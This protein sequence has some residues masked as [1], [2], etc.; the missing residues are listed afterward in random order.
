MSR[1]DKK[2][3]KESLEPVELAAI[4]PKIMTKP[5][6]EILDELESAIKQNKMK[7]QIGDWIRKLKE[8]SDIQ[9]I[10]GRLKSP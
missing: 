10:K 6:P 8:K 1:A 7:A 5:L 2:E 4:Q 3:E 9:I